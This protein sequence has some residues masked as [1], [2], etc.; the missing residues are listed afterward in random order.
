MDG[1]LIS[2]IMSMAVEYNMDPKLIQAV[3]Q[4][5][6]KGNVKAVGEKGEIGLMQVMPANF[7][8]I[9]KQDMFDPEVNLLLGISLLIDSRTR[10]NHKVDNTWLLCYNLGVK[11]ARN[12]KYPKQF[13]YYTEVMKE[14]RSIK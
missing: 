9:R 1:A 10:C 8:H 4:V 2:L 6:S 5:E 13:H 11:K 7:K 3:I 14:Y 12:I